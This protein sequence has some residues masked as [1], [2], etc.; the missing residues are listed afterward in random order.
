MSTPCAATL[1]E[2]SP[3]LVNSDDPRRLKV[4]NPLGS[5][6]PTFAF[7]A[8]PRPP[9]SYPQPDGATHTSPMLVKPTFGSSTLPIR[10]SSS[11]VSAGRSSMC[12]A[13]TAFSPEQALATVNAAAI[14]LE[15]DPR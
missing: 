2:S 9:R 12:V 14:K 3:L 7:T 8:G 13:G 11:S 6:F 5:S 1:P 4:V 15:R 10:S